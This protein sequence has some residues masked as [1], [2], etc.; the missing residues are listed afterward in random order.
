MNFGAALKGFGERLGNFGITDAQR[1]AMDADAFKNF[2]NDQLWNMGA[3][4]QGQA[5][6]RDASRWL[7]GMGQTQPAPTTPASAPLPDMAMAPFPAPQAPQ[8]GF[9]LNFGRG[10]GM[11]GGGLLDMGGR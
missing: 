9:G 11:R 4:L 8:M 5:G 1:S 6:G 7:Q 10:R 3:M 2:R